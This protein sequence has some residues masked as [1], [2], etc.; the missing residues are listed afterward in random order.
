MVVFLF[1]IILAAHIRETREQV[2]KFNKD[3]IKRSEGGVVGTLR[4]FFSVDTYM[5]SLNFMA[6]V[7]Q[8][9]VFGR[10]K[11]EEEER[12]RGRWNAHVRSFIFQFPKNSVSKN[13]V[14]SQSTLRKR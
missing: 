1:F 6:I 2:I 9:L 4:H 14:P 8:P 12:G 13:G 11:K 3:A 5:C 10:E 7:V